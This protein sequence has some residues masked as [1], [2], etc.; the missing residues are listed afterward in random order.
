MGA[1]LPKF[2]ITT[3]PLGTVKVVNG[4]E[5][6]KVVVP[7]K[8]VTQDNVKSNANLLVMV[9]NPNCGHCELQT[10]T[11]ERYLH[12][13]KKSKL[14]LIC[15]PSM[16]TYL[17]SFEKMTNCYKYPK[18][19]VGMDSTAFIRKVYLYKDMP[20]INIYNKDR[21]LIRTFIGGASMDSL[22]H[23]IQ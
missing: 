6:K 18:I 1:P 10:D 22:K 9:F 21:K 16:G 13:F 8:N 5:V 20:Q 11:L 12:L 17:E 14:V 7:S 2:R 19:L 23:Y 4:T 15:A 3:L